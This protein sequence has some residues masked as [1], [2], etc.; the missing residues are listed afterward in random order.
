MSCFA[1]QMTLSKKDENLFESQNASH[2]TAILPVEGQLPL[3]D[4]SLIPQ[5]DPW[6][7]RLFVTG[8]VKKALRLSLNDI[9]EQ[10][11]KV[12]VTTS[13]QQTGYANPFY[14]RVEWS[15]IRLRHVLLASGV[16]EGTRFV[17]FAGIENLQV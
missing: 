1:E 17:A 2:V 7:Y 12:S 8:L 15:G 6:M 11:P 10:F 16:Q 5:V 9:Y 3:L 4:K 14:R 13:G